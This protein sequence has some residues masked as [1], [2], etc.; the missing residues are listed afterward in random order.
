M[1]DGR[2][3]WPTVKDELF[4]DLRALHGRMGMIEGTL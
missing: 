1:S 4:E 2:R 3:L